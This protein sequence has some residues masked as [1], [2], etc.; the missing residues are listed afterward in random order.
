VIGEVAHLHLTSDATG[1]VDVVSGRMTELDARRSVRDYYDSI[2]WQRDQRGRYRDQTNDPREL[3]ARYNINANL[4][5]RRLLPQ[6]RR[7]LDAGCG[8]ILRPEQRELYEAFDL[9]VCVDFSTTALFEARQKV[10]SRVCFV[11][12]DVTMLPFRSGS[13]DAVLSSHV[14]YHIPADE[15][16]Q[17]IFDLYRV[18]AAGG[19]CV[20]VYAFSESTVAALAPLIVASRG[21]LRRLKASIRER[22]RSPQVPPTVR[23]ARSTAKP[24]LVTSVP[25]E[26]P[27][28]P[29]VYFFAHDWKWLHDTLPSSW[30]VEIRSWASLDTETTWRLFRDTA[31]S[32][33]VLATISWLEDHLPTL[34]ARVGSYPMIVVRRAA[35]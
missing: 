3:L 27:E 35:S 5:V 22:L 26:H 12:A 16:A 25:A 13:F 33:R 4:R 34:M 1:F 14:L 24:E 21:R 15:Q 28:V 11:Q 30:D 8:P 23:P 9:A 10:E 6:G 2:G 7:L 29:T 19:T 20:I 31:R 17:A 18:L 32:R